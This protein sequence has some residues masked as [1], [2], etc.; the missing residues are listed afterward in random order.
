MGFV[1]CLQAFRYHRKE[2]LDGWFAA[3]CP[4]LRVQ[5]FGLR[6]DFGYT[7]HRL[8]TH[9]QWLFMHLWGLYAK[10]LF[11]EPK[12]LNHPKPLSPKPYST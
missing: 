2:N 6:V 4:N 10:S 3:L 11:S 12:A 7:S 5:V 8:E 1:G 9:V